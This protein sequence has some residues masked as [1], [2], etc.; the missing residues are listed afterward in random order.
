MLS[1]YHYS[2]MC[3]V[4]DE[5][6]CAMDTYRNSMFAHCLGSLAHSVVDP[7]V[8]LVGASGGDYAI[9]GA[10]LAAVVTV[11]VELLL[12]LLSFIALAVILTV[13]L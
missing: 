4:I 9:L 8:G 13:L 10:H 7:M 1:G 2:L 12:L 11:S 3:G 6:Y 5:C